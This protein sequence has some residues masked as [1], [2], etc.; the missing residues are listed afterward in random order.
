[1][2]SDGFAV[3]V[4]ILEVIV[5]FAFALPPI[6]WVFVRWAAWWGLG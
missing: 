5:L 4:W 1:M 6:A 2:H 3:F